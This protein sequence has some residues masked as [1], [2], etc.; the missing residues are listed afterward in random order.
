MRIRLARRLSPVLLA[1]GGML[2]PGLAAAQAAP[3]DEP[4]AKRGRLTI[5]QQ[6]AVDNGDV[7]G[8]TPIDLEFQSGSRI[9]TLQFS[10]SMPLEMNDPEESRFVSLGDAQARLLYRRGVRN[11]AVEAELGY[12]ESDVDDDI[13]FDP[14]SNSLV[15]LDGGRVAYS[16]ARIGYV[17]GQQAKLGGELGFGYS[18]R[19]YTGTTD[20]SLTDS[21]TRE[22]HATLYL[23]PTPLVRAR[24]LASESRTDSDGGTD[25][26]ISRAGAGASIQ[27][28]KLT[29]LDL[30]LA[31]SDIRRE[32]DD[33]SEERARGPSYRLNLTHARPTGDWS[34]SLSSDP[35]TQGRRGNFTLGRALETPQYRLSVSLGVSHFQDGYDPIFQIGYDRTLSDLSK[36]QAS[37][38][39]A[40]VTDDDGD[41]AINTDLSAGYSRQ[42]GRLSSFSADIRYRES[43]V[44]AGDGQDARTLALS[45]SYSRAIYSELS[46]V[47][48]ANVIR[49][50]NS[51]GTRDDDERIWLGLS[52]SFDW[53]P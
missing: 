23:E 50:K 16:N 8:I 15:T 27:L 10:M 28:G 5:G 41:E 31:R 11:S 49:G 4:P 37:L 13:L 40:A 48:G 21:R 44:Q 34:L 43:E 42:I 51:D 17:F 9:Q 36:F 12:R 32:E 33:G 7:I 19:D 30:E 24:I 47:A 18:R 38:R 3:Q 1:A 46:L 29:N 35:G 25:S 2:L 14:E 22:G 53:L 20:P 45:L 52:R 6:I 39:R 26:R